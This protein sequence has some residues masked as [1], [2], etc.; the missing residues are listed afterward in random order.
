MQRLAGEELDKA[1]GTIY[2]AIGTI[3]VQAKKEEAKKDLAE[4]TETFNMRVN[5]LT[6]QEE[7]LKNRL[8]ELKNK[9]EKANDVKV[10]K[11]DIDSYARKMAKAQFAQYGMIGMDDEIIANYAKDIGLVTHLDV[12][13]EQIAFAEE[14]GAPVER[15][16]GR[17]KGNDASHAHED[18]VDL[19]VGPAIRPGRR[20]QTPTCT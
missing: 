16:R 17:V 9:L 1:S 6:K 20:S 5:M 10:E 7:K 15:H 8:V 2:R 11:E 14:S 12:S 19:Q 18:G 13:A 3:I 4:K